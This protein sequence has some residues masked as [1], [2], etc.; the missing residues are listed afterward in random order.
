[1]FREGFLSA[2][3]GWLRSGGVF[4]RDSEADVFGDVDV[5]QHPDF[6]DGSEEL[7]RT[8]GRRI[9]SGRVFVKTSEEQFRGNVKSA[10]E[11]LDVFLIQFSLTAEDFGNDARGPEYFH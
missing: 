10:A 3:V 7:R 1:M 2:A 5:A 9:R 11:T 8:H 4:F 6:V